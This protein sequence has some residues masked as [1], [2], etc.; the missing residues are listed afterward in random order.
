MD[1]TITL[2]EK[3]LAAK[4]YKILQKNMVSRQYG[5]VDLVVSEPGTQNLVFVDVKTRTEKK[6]KIHPQ[7]SNPQVDV[8]SIK[9][10][11]NNTMELLE[12]FE[13]VSF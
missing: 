10:A 6:L 8:I 7:F 9:L 3:Y 2:A 1:T 12:H 11:P 5:T 4:G 13:N